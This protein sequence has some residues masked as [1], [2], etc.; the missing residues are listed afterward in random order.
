MDASLTGTSAQDLID[1][2]SQAQAANRP[3]EVVRLLALAEARFPGHPRVL[4]AFGMWTLQQGD[5]QTARQYLERAVLVDPNA[6]APWLNLALACRALNAVQDEFNS[7]Q[8]ALQVDPYFSLALLQKARWLETHHDRKAAAP[9]FHA[10][11]ASLPR[12]G[13]QSPAFVSAVAYARNVI[14]QTNEAMF[15]FIENRVSQVR[16]KYADS[17]QQRFGACMDILVGRKRLY[18]SQPTFMHFPHL[19]AIQFFDRSEFAWL[20]EI[21]AAT[22]DICGELAAI[23]AKDAGELTPY[24]QHPVG[25]PVNQWQELNHSLRWSAYYLWKEGH[26][27]YEHQQRC[28]VTTAALARLPMIR[29][30]GH[31]PTAFFSILKPRTRIPPHTGVTNTRLAVHLPL[32][33]PPACGFRVGYE[34]RQ[35]QRGAAWVFDDTIEHEAWNDSDEL[36]AILIFDIWNPYLTEAERALVG[37]ATEAIAEFQS[38]D[39]AWSL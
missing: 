1:A 9:V 10:F 28:P 27:I 19:P 3:Q 21:E 20:E 17:P 6:A 36:R 13:D 7:L 16:E 38:S 26:A 30:A 24:V 33:V 25:A 8:K 37:A 29:I 23:L 2:A 35:W 5:A 4:S 39:G 22:D 11:L 14:T 18:A 34:T 32:I 31:A 12:G 15:G